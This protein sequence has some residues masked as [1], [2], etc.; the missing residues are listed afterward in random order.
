[1]NGNIQEQLKKVFAHVE[2]YNREMG[3]VQAKITNIERD[4]KDIKG[5]IKKV[6]NRPPAWA[7]AIIAVL[8]AV[9]GWLI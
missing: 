9:V 8:T 1:M 4:I 5:S 6:I 3:G 2:T 7:T